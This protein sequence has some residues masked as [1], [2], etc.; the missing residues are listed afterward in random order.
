[1]GLGLNMAALA[2]SAPA[3]APESTVV[4]MQKGVAELKQA[5]G[6]VVRAYVP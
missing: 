3:E 1:M 5:Q 2:E 4:N 6:D